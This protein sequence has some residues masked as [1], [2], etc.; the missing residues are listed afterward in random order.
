MAYVGRLARVTRDC[1]ISGSIGGGADM[2]LDIG[3]VGAIVGAIEALVF[4]ACFRL[5][6]E[7][8]PCRRRAPRS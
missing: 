3:T 7:R 8:R 5:T 6:G 4:W 1:Y 2:D